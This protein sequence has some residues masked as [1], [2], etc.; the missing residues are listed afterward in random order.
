ML[1]GKKLKVKI[2]QIFLQRKLLIVSFQ[3]K[4]QKETKNITV[5]KEFPYHTTLKNAN[6]IL[7]MIIKLKSFFQMN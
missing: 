2:V 3:I 1:Y 5:M 4:I 6:I 7:K